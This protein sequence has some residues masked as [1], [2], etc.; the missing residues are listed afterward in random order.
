MGGSSFTQGIH[1]DI[2]TKFVNG[3]NLFVASVSRL[4][5][6]TFL[7]LPLI[8]TSVIRIATM[9]MECLGVSFVTQYTFH[10][11]VAGYSMWLLYGYIIYQSARNKS[12]TQPSYDDISALLLTKGVPL[13]LLA[14]INLVLIEIPL[15][16]YGPNH[17]Y[18]ALL[19]RTVWSIII[20]PIVSL[21]M[22]EQY[23][24][25]DG[26]IQ[27]FPI[28]RI[29]WPQALCGTVIIQ[30]F[31]GLL[32]CINYSMFGAYA[33]IA[34]MVGVYLCYFV[35]ILDGIFTATVYQNYTYHN[36]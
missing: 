30:L 24:V 22:Y 17:I 33:I 14:S 20:L 4:C 21:L 27:S 13:V 19:V 8:A 1:M 3:S 25:I 36:E 16:L 28:T 23:P 34:G 6:P 31:Y 15:L 29:L 9:I 10:F 26:I 35:T 11:Y 2:C 5:T 12:D 32:T 18:I 7:L